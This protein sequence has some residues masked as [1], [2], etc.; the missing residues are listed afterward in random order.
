VRNYQHQQVT[1]DVQIFVGEDLSRLVPSPSCPF[2]FDP[3]EYKEP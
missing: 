3:H 1:K 2:E